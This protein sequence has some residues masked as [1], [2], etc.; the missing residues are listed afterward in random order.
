M[1]YRDTEYQ[2]LQTANPTG[3]K[4]TVLIAGEKIRT[5]PAYNRASAIAQRAIDKLLKSGNERNRYTFTGEDGYG[6][7]DV[8]MG[9][10]LPPQRECE[11]GD[12]RNAEGE[13]PVWHRNSRLR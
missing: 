11:D 3:W 1:E 10:L 13:P 8:A 7:L 9:P 4:W 6:S 2:I 5:G 12:N